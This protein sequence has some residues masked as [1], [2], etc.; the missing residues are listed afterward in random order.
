MRKQYSY[1]IIELEYNV[2]PVKLMKTISDYTERYMRLIHIEPDYEYT[3]EIPN[4]DGVKYTTKEKCCLLI[5][6]REIEL[7]V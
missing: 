6:E 1:E 7:D 2:T 4:K 3:N 5:F